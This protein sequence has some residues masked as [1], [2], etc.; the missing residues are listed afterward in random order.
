[1][2]SVG[3]LCDHRG[4]VAFHSSRETTMYS[5]PGRRIAQFFSPGFDGAVHEILAT[6]C[7]SG[8]LVLRKRDNDAFS[9]LTDVDAAML[10]PSVAAHLNPVDY[11]NLQYVRLTLI[12]ATVGGLLIR[13]SYFYAESLSP[14]PSQTS[15][16]LGAFSTTSTAQLRY[17]DP[18]YR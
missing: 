8:T 15:G 17:S 12:L 9:H 6:I 5:A 10:N 14:S 16:R 18:L 11:P 13:R 4:V 3:V 7:F 2:I 1:M